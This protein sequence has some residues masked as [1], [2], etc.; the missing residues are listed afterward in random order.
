MKLLR[1]FECPDCGKV[2]ERFIDAEVTHVDCECGHVAYRVI[3]MPMVQLEGI[4]GAFPG[5]H[6]R[7]ARIRE[8][9]FRQNIRRNHENGE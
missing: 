4:T 7:W 9:K 1:D 8:E 3:G 6:D 5:A 2:V